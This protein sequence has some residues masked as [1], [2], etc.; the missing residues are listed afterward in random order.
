MPE[1]RK[2]THAEQYERHDNQALKPVEPSQ[3]RGIVIRH[4][5]SKQKQQ[6]CCQRHNAQTNR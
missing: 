6:A 2:Q 5:V 1:S 3:A 4:E